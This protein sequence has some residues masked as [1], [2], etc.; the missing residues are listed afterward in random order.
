MSR[1]KLVVPPNLLKQENVCLIP[2]EA[3][4]P[5]KKAPIEILIISINH[6]NHVLMAEY[7]I[8]Q[9][10]TFLYIFMYFLRLLKLF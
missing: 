9:S 8:L 2:R 6:S 5:S 10:N 4:H 1:I 7:F 3:E